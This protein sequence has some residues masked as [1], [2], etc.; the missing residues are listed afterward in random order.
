MGI[1][2]PAA[3]RARA[4]FIVALGV[5]AVR[6]PEY[7]DL[8][9]EAMESPSPESIRR[10]L[11]LSRGQPWRESVLEAVAE[12]GMAASNEILGDSCD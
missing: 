8:V 7:R 6:Q 5:V 9:S 10:V 1:S 2:T 4:H 11:E 3:Q 12:V